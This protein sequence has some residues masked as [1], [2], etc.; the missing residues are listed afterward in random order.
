MSSESE[1]PLP[2][3]IGL[4][5]REDRFLVRRRPVGTVYAG[6]WEFPGGKCEP[7]ES[8]A[9]ATKRECLEETGMAVVLGPLRHTTT[10]RYPHGLVEL[11]FFDCVTEDPL[12]EPIAESGFVW[13]SAQALRSLR[14]PEANDAILEELAGICDQGTGLG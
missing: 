11:H 3:G 1:Q 4:I 9:L 2:I 13:T 6:F 14:F 10:Y 7:G 12:A 5:R 8:P